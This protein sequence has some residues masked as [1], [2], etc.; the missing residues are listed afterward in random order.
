MRDFEV[1]DIVDF[2]NYDSEY[3]GC[4][5]KY[6]GDEYLIVEFVESGSEQHFYLHSVTNMVAHKSET[7][8]VAREMY[9][10]VPAKFKACMEWTKLVED[11]CE[12]L[13]KEGWRK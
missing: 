7:E 8:K 1:N 3:V 10:D 5:I 6:I 12:H 11:V 2:N 4:I 13:A 9:G